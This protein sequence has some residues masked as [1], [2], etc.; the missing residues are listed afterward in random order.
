MAEKFPRTRFS[1]G[2][3][4]LPGSTMW[5]HSDHLV[6][7]MFCE[8]STLMECSLRLYLPSLYFCN[9]FATPVKYSRQRIDWSLFSYL[10]KQKVC[11]YEIKS[12]GLY[13]E[14]RFSTSVGKLSLCW[15]FTQRIALS[16]GEGKAEKPVRG[17]ASKSDQEDRF[18]KD[19]VVDSRCWGILE[20]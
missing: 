10:S 17:L 5:L 14:D 6:T 11:I 3:N 16:S 8:S 2:Y 19:A 9:H 7:T 13:V 1:R 4:V 15:R 18:F 12:F 20:T